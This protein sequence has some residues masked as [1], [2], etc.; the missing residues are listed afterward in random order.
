MREE[1]EPPTEVGGPRR[2]ALAE[3]VAHAAR[4]RKRLGR[5]V[6]LEAHRVPAQSTR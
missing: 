4:E 5:M 6:S 2:V 3:D 1:S